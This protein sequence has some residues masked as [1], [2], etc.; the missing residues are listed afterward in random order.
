MHESR[1]WTGAADVPALQTRLPNF[2]LGHL[3]L[4]QIRKHTPAC[5]WTAAGIRTTLRLLRVTPPPVFE[6][7]T[8]FVDLARILGK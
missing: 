1:E 7:T 2:G 8:I 3:N 5:I 4:S 6:E